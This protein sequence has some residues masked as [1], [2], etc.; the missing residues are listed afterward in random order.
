[1]IAL[2]RVNVPW[3]QASRLY[4]VRQR[5]CKLSEGDDPGRTPI[6]AQCT[7]RALVLVDQK[8]PFCSFALAR[9]SNIT[10]LRNG[11]ERKVVNALPRTDVD[12][13][14]AQDA[15]GLIYVQKLLGLDL[16]Q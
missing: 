14:F 12:A 13:A 9:V 11:V 10:A 1:M 5:P 7:A 3:C 6:D 2:S 4:L 16:R 8:E 15:F